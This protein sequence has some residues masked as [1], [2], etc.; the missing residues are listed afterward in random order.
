MR[1][2]TTG[3]DYKNYVRKKKELQAGIGIGR[4]VEGGE[5]GEGSCRGGAVESHG[6]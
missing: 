3:S 1:S 4:V 5:R 6:K 2:I